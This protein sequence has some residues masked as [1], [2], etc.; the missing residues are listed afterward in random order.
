M[1]LII[2]EFVGGPLD[3]EVRRVE[4]KPTYL[5]PVLDQLSTLGDSHDVF[6]QA[7][8]YYLARRKTGEWFYLT[9]EAMKTRGLA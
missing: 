9:L 1:A 7:V 5:V 8:T 6:S 3:G 2:V 4:N